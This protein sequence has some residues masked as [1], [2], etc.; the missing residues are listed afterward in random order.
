MLGNDLKIIIKKKNK[1]LDN[2][3]GTEM[4][5]EMEG[6]FFFFCNFLR[7]RPLWL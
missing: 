1:A 3:G 2:S 5:V 4:E 7:D 6:E